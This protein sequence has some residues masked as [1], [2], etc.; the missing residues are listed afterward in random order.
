M[1]AWQRPPWPDLVPHCLDSHSALGVL[2]ARPCFIV[3]VDTG[4]QNHVPYRSTMAREDRV[5][6]YCLDRSHS[7]MHAGTETGG[8]PLRRGPHPQPLQKSA[9]HVGFILSGPGSATVPAGGASGPEF[10][11][12]LL[13]STGYGSALRACDFPGPSIRR[14][15]TA[16]GQ[17]RPGI[18]GLPQLTPA[19]PVGQCADARAG[20]SSCSVRRGSRRPRVRSV[21]PSAVSDIQRRWRDVGR[22]YPC[23]ELD[24]R[25]HQHAR[26]AVTVRR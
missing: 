13:S 9:S 26:S 20:A 3:S 24:D 12:A 15:A 8:P 7:A 1:E 2:T 4:V 11:R 25:S 16:R 17:R 6:T 5:G 14:S 23:T 18:G 22:L 10:P 21:P 19:E